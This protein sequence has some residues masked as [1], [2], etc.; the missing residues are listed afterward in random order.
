MPCILFT[1]NYDKKMGNSNHAEVPGVKLLDQWMQENNLTVPAFAKKIFRSS[2]MV[3]AWRLRRAHPRILDIL[4]I[5]RLT[6][7]K[8]EKWLNKC[9]AKTLNKVLSENKP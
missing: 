3:H 8:P 7:I 5:Y 9:E 2:D 6:G 1:K 4:L